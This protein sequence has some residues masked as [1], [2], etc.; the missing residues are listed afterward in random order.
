MVDKK[1]INL[2]TKII[3]IVLAVLALTAI[4][5]AI[6]MS[7]KN[8]VIP[9]NTDEESTAFKN[10]I[11]DEPES[12]SQ[13]ET[14][15]QTEAET[16]APETEPPAP[17]VFYNPLTGI[18]CSEE[19]SKQ[20]PVGI[21]INNIREAIPQEG[22]TYGDVIY[23]CLAE[24]GITRLFML[25][26]DYAKVP[27]AGSVRSARDY[28]LDFAQ[29]HNALFFHAGGS[30]KAYGEIASRN[31]DN[32]AGVRMT[33]PNAFY[34]DPW[35]LSKMALEHTMVITGEGMVNAIK[36]RNANTQLKE[37]FVNPFNFSQEKIALEGN[38][39]NCV[40]LPFSN[41]QA[42][43]LKYN[44][45]TGTYQRWQYNKPHA[46]KEGNQLE[47][48]NILVL[49]CSHTGALD[50]SGRIDVTTTGNGEGYY[51][52]GGKYIDIKYSKAST[53]SEISFTNTDGSP[54]LMNKGK[55][56]IA[57]LKTQNKANINMN[58]NK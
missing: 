4:I 44:A 14:Q 42:P 22:I 18:E 52:N 48:T 49:F 35:R 33:I 27:K 5:V 9:T 39:A 7:S 57:I 6:V 12:N 3:A 23:E 37:G 20:R 56:Y 29:N 28:Y 55:T 19:L 16:T 11:T 46:D 15:E 34:R 45:S 10:N 54:L 26:Q 2:S 40:Y 53:D 50:S 24:G 32:F 51:I 31:I 13:T 36:Y 1:K 58:Y 43:Y 41:Y 47:F 17:T 8:K 38:D 21:M 25:I 30:E